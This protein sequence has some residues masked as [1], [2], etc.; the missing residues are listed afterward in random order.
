VT[1]KAA[2][3]ITDAQEIVWETYN[4]GYVY[5]GYTSVEPTEQLLADLR[6]LIAAAPGPEAA[7]VRELLPDK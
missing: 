2:L 4:D 1:K 6:Y 5:G 3:I 7:R